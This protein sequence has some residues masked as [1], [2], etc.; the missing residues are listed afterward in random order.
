MR[1]KGPSVDP[2]VEDSPSLH[3]KNV[4]G[5]ILWLRQKT[6]KWRFHV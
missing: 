4:H 3:K 1:I 5:R 6:S 2:F